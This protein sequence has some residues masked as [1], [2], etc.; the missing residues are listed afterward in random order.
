MVENHE[1]T[2]EIEST[3]LAKQIISKAIQNVV[4]RYNAFAPIISSFRI[5]YSDMVP[6]MGIDQY[7]RLVINPRF[8]VE[9]EQYAQ[10]LL[11]HEVLHVFMGHTSAGRGELDFTDD[12]A[13][14]ELVNIAEDCAI[15]Q[16]ITE[17][18]PRGAV[19]PDKLAEAFGMKVG[20][21]WYRYQKDDTVLYRDES[22]EYY[23]KVILEHQQEQVQGLQSLAQVIQQL[24]A[25][26]T[27]ATGNVNTKAIQDALDKMGIEHIS[28]EEVNDIVTDMAKAI[29]KAQGNGYGRLV[30][31]A[32]E[33][34]EPKVDWRPLLR[35]T[36]RN[37]EKK[38]WT[39]HTKQTYKRVSRRS[40][41]ILFPKRYGHKISVTLSFDTSGSISSDMVNQFLS[42]IQNCLR[43]SEIKECSLWH[44]ENYWY[45]T[46]EQL[47]KDVE[48][49][50]ESGG[51]SESCMGNAEQHCKADLHF[52]FSDGEHGTNY[53]FK[54][55]HKNIELIWR[56]NDIKEI[57]KEF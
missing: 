1:T 51:T 42:E 37:A 22:A 16:F 50:F 49:V 57:R 17:P 53:G 43:Y 15:N 11:I 5:V 33:I 14:N 35:A 10:G 47:I 3:V 28:A 36:I 24:I 55:P 27:D 31:F 54:E 8:L 38:V 7:A 20:S 48:K 29:S 34:L 52:H 18:L 30:D 56:D 12:P 9:N 25:D 2:N 45:G 41:Q 39:L 19:T 23:Y 6:T 26:N 44:T 32:R 13:H 4:F 40:G 21:I 46:P